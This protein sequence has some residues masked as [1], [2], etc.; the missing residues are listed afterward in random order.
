M[1]VLSNSNQ[2][3]ES[4]YSARISLQ[5]NWRNVHYLSLAS[6]GHVYRCESN[7]NYSRH[8]SSRG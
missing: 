4:V 7:V 1:P 5:C 2:N 6:F 3:I 8:P